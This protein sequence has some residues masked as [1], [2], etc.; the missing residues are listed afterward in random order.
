MSKSALSILSANLNALKSARVPLSQKEIATKAGVD[1]TTVGRTLNATNAPSVDKLDGL[2][3]AFGVQ[4]WQLLVPE[5]D[6]ARP[7]VLAGSNQDRRVDELIEIWAALPEPRRRVVLALADQ[8]R[9]SGGDMLMGLFSG[10]F[11]AAVASTQS[12]DQVREKHDTSGQA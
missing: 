8:L 11:Q 4:A 9:G 1:Q 12:P 6:P 7:P 3:K 5:F 2:A 10:A